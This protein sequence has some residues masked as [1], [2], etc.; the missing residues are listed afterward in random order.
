MSA[1]LP[2]QAAS[3]P[4]AP[5][6]AA[7]GHLLMDYHSGAILA[8]N[9]AGKR[10]EPASLT[11]IM[12]AYTVFRELEE[13]NIS[14]NDQ[15]LVS[16]K[17][18]KTPGSRMFIEVGKQVSVDDLIHGMIIASGNDACVAL[19]E[20]IA[21]NEEAF[22]ALMN[23]HVLELGME[24]THF[25]NATGLPDPNHY[26]TPEDILKVTRAIIREFPQFYPL[27]SIK[28]FT[29]NGI[30]Q[31]N[32]N[33]LLWRDPSVDGVKTGHTEA[34]GYCLVTSAKRENMRLLSV[35]MG[36]A[37]DSAR[38]KE[39]QTLLNYGF[40]FYQT[41]RL[42]D[43]G[44]TLKQL[45]VWKGEVDNLNLGLEEDLYVTNPRGSYNKLTARI[46]LKDSI[47][48]PVPRG[49]VRGKVIIE[50]DGEIIKEVPLVALRGVREGGIIHNLVDS[51]LMIF[52]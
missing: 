40:R 49:K 7:T 19:A 23:K 42:F 29:Y 6:I 13:G 43:G 39:S 4:A 21:G 35:V 18:W 37:S 33:R 41:H 25:T 50:H 27:Y 51:V 16:K 3:V 45:R 46:H 22:A 17:A 15:V 11:K 24:N 14:L 12:T 1:A 30:T 47:M 31:K 44:E 9:N 8:E 28:E 36:T 10:L 32:R 2:A 52:Q 34:A 20:H 38:A 48:A 5:K 26:T